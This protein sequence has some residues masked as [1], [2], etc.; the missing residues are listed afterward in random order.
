[1]K[2]GLEA[3]HRIIEVAGEIFADRGFR[4]TTVREICRCAGVNVAAINYHF[5]DKERLYLAVLKHYRDIAFQTFRRTDLLVQGNKP[6]EI[7]LAEFIKSFIFNILGQGQPSC[8]G[9]LMAREYI[10]PTSAMDT[11]IEEEIRPFFMR[12]KGI[13]SQLLGKQVDDSESTL[14]SM[15]VLGQ[16]LY[17][18][19]SR[20]VINRLLQK[21]DY[22]EAEIKE[23]A[24][25]ITRFSLEAF[26]G[27]SKQA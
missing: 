5:G 6:P 7:Q 27:L 1:M 24:E 13:V 21:E 14:C 4:E 8:F 9:K 25:H 16:C 26:S 23:I 2:S 15:S 22:G 12:L 3:K 10:E 11:I 20:S 17:F 18:K 19:Y